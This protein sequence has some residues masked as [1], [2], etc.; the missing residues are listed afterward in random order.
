MKPTKLITEQNRCTILCI[1][2]ITDVHLTVK[3]NGKQ[4]VNYIESNGKTGRYSYL[5]FLHI[6]SK[7]NIKNS[8]LPT[9]KLTV[10]RTNVYHT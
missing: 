7:C 6:Y 9:C 1:R 10:D 4:K 5:G 8:T 2:P 3:Y